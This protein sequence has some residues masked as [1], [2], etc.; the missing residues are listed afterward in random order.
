V[1]GHFDDVLQLAE[2][3]LVSV[4][5]P[6][7]DFVLSGSGDPVHLGVEGDLVDGGASFVFIDGLLE[8]GDVPNVELLVLAAGHDVPTTVGGDGDGVDVAF[9]GFELE[10]DGVVD[11]PDFEPA[12][13]ADADEIGLD[14]DALAFIDGAEPDLG[15]PIVVVV[16]LSGEL[17]VSEGVEEADF[18]FGACGEDLPVVRGEGDSEDLLLVS[19]ESLGGLAGGEVPEPDVVVPRGGEQVFA[20]VGDGEVGD[21][22][23][24]ASERLLGEASEFVGVALDEFPDDDGLVPGA[25][26]HHVNLVL[27]LVGGDDARDPVGVALQVAEVLDVVLDLLVCLA[28]LHCFRI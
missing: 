9:V 27:A 22:V 20:F 21:E 12:V 26:D 19:D 24:V 6:D 5:L 14:S 17:A 3:L 25:R 15:D 11:V 10:P 18:P 1:L 13:P 16:G 8:V 28:L 2:R 23:G 7:S 4:N